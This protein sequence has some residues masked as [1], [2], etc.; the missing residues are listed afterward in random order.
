M[1][2]PGI[3]AAV[4]LASRRC[5]T[6]TDLE[7][8]TQH[9]NESG[10]SDKPDALW[11]LVEDVYR[12]GMHPGIQV[13]VRH[14]NE[15]VLDRVIGHASG[16]VPG[17]RFD[18]NRAV[19]LTLDTPVNL[20]SAAK[21]VTGMAMHKLEEQGALQLDDLVAEHI[22]GFEQ[23]G[24][25]SITIRHVLTHR[26]GVSALPAEAFDLDVLSDPEAIERIV[27]GLRPTTHPGAIPEYHAVSG[28]L[29][30]ETVTRR[31]AGRSLR[32]V[33]A[34]EIKRPLGLEWFDYGVAPEDVDRVAQNVATG[35]PPGPVMNL[36]M[37]RVLG[38]PWGELLRLSNDPR[39]LGAVVPSGNVIT[40]ARDTAIFYQCIMD[41]GVA[42]GTRVFDDDTVRRALEAPH[43]AL[44]IDR[45][46]GLP[47]RYAS[48][49][50]LGSDTMSP[51][52]WN[53]PRA[54]GHVGMSNLFTWADPERNLVVAILTTGKP[55]LGPHLV[56]LVKLLTGINEIYPKPQ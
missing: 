11:A 56:P 3:D 32:D 52:G 45:M 13:C 43:D 37:K 17:Q 12:S 36:F 24:K 31:A 29:I 42:A 33:L 14:D 55:V 21:A 8:V 47:L 5:S 39:F 48:G 4:G 51:F 46:L 49:F 2:L 20:F 10:P 40:T 25:Q 26:A 1:G 19:P 53:R 38:K 50:M 34:T 54:F 28:G 35:L 30:M 22:P 6:P 9:G 41:G 16:I 18:R 7:I 23:H 27:C 44:V 15:V